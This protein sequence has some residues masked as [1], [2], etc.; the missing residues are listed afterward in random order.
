M[1]IDGDLLVDGGAFNNYPID[2]MARAGTARVIGVNIVRNHSEAANFEELPG[3]WALAWD[4]IAGRRRKY[5]VPSLMSM[6]TTATMLSSAARE[7]NAEGLADLELRIHLPSVGMLDWQA[8]DHAVNVGYRHASKVLEAISPEELALYQPRAPRR[9]V[10][11][12]P[13]SEVDFA[14]P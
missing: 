13:A 6:L 9:A 4:R 7:Q 14:L 12:T 5:R 8:F 3:N 10:A 11:A 2:V 1:A